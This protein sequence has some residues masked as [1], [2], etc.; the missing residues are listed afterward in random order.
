MLLLFLLLSLTLT[1]IT[2]QNIVLIF[3]TL[4]LVYAFVSAAFWFVKALLKLFVVSVV[5]AAQRNLSWAT[6]PCWFYTNIILC[7][8]QSKYSHICWRYV[9]IRR[10]FK[11]IVDMSVWNMK[12]IFALILSNKLKRRR[13]FVGDIKSSYNGMHKCVLGSELQKRM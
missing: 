13:Q 1:A 5:A 6:T 10:E 4:S 3:Y 9:C 7:V 11:S 2:M 12:E 8:L